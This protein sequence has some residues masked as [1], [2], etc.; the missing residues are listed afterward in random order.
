[1]HSN[2]QP[3]K[4]DNLDNDRPCYMSSKQSGAN[5]RLSFNES[6]PSWNTVCI[7]GWVA[8]IVLPPTCFHRRRHHRHHH[9]DDCHRLGVLMMV[10]AVVS[11]SW[12]V[13]NVANGMGPAV[14]WSHKTRMYILQPAIG[15]Q[16]AATID[17]SLLIIPPPPSVRELR[18][19]CY[20]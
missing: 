19:D 6:R 5:S 8:L 11:L 3:R 15:E 17:I 20:H 13:L 4:T 9:K 1:M 12:L 14:W 10:A 2:K 18:V 16:T 7:G